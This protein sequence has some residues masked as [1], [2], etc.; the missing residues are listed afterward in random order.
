MK[1]LLSVLFLALVPGL[2]TVAETADPAMSAKVGKKEA[3]SGITYQGGDGSSFEKAVGSSAQRIRWRVFLRK[4]N[5]LRKNMGIMKS[6]RRA[7]SNMRKSSMIWLRSGRKKA[8]KWSFISIFQDFSPPGARE[9]NF[10]SLFFS[11]LF[12]GSCLSGFLPFRIFFFSLRELILP[13]AWIVVWPRVR[14]EGRREWEGSGLVCK[15]ERPSSW[16]I[17]H[18]E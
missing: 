17:C 14:M 3:A 6:S 9:E 10:L 2:R 5:G 7:S 11:I 13:A 15:K 12:R 16:H 8:R 1:T 4:G 18:D